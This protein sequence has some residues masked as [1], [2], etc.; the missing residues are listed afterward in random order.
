MF[1]IHF[2]NLRKGGNWTLVFSLGVD[3]KIFGCE[4]PRQGAKGAVLGKMKVFRRIRFEGKL[5]TK[6]ASDT[7]HFTIQSKFWEP[8]APEKMFIQQTL[9][10]LGFFRVWVG[11]RLQQLALIGSIAGGAAENG[12]FTPLFVLTLSSCYRY[13]S[14]RFLFNCR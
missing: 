2:P 14:F 9:N 1:K 8:E 10:M 6:N 13:N 11:G 4:A 5:S 7:K 3:C 12:L